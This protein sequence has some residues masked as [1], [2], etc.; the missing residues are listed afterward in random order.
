MSFLERH[1]WILGPIYLGTVL[2]GAVIILSRPSGLTMVVLGIFVGIALVWVLVS[3]LWPAKADRNCPSCES[4]GLVRLDP[5]TT[6][7][8]KCSDC[9]W[10]DPDAS[11]W[12][13]AEEEGPLEEL[14]LR[15]RQSRRHTGN[16]KNG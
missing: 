16:R 1:P 15:E 14:V 5:E 9:G 6:T 10:T 3:A 13:L 7:G 2:L 8:L 4:E 11:S 12:F